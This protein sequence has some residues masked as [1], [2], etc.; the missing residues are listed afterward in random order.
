MDW[1]HDQLAHDLADHLGAKDGR[2]IWTDMQLGPAG[3]PRPDVYTIDPSYM[4]ANPT[5]YEIKVSRSDFLSDVTSGK[6]QKY[7]TYAGA[8][9][10]AVPAGLIDKKELPG[11]CGLMVRSETGWRTMRRPNREHV[12]LPQDAMLKLLID[13]VK[14]V[15]HDR[16]CEP[17]MATRWSVAAKARQQLGD[18]V[19]KALSDVDAYRADAEITLT[20][21]REIEKAARKAYEDERHKARLETKAVTDE[22]C[23]LLGLEKWNAFQARAAIRDLRNSLS[24]DS[25]VQQVEDALDQA[26]RSLASAARQLERLPSPA[27][28]DKRHGLCP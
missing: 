19:A 2:M 1:K 27:G 20:K 23:S 3:S 4:H 5:A 21:A 28:L 26:R 6:W 13:G 11:G 24:A 17:R 7:K 9:V 18:E 25:R 22:L 16:A 10:F 8:V 15:R 12:K 14:R